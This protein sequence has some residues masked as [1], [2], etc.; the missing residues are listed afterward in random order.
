M[1][2]LEEKW[3]SKT[4]LSQLNSAQTLLYEWV[5]LALTEKWHAVSS[6]SQY[7]QNTYKFIERHFS[8]ISLLD[9]DDEFLVDD[10]YPFVLKDME[11]YYQQKD[12]E[13]PTAVLSSFHR[14]LETLHDI[15]SVKFIGGS[16]I[17]LAT[18]QNQLL[19]EDEYQQ[20]L[21]IV[22]KS[23]LDEASKKH[24]SLSII[25][26]RRL[27]LRKS[28]IFKLKIKD[29][30]LQSKNLHIHGI[31]YDRQKTIRGNRLLPYSALLTIDEMKQFEKYI[32]NQSLEKNSE[33]NLLLF[34]D[35]VKI[36]S[37]TV[38]IQKVTAYIQALLH[39]V[40]G[41][42]KVTIKSFRKTFASEVFLNLTMKD[43]LEDILKILHL[44]R[45]DLNKEIHR[46]FN[47]SVVVK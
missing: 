19:T 44:K 23:K 35:K 17:N 29:I 39:S 5:K 11:N 46:T 14:S 37:K 28:E 24:I 36:Y 30:C 15:D 47:R 32:N 8:Q 10:L 40:T 1:D 31:K 13:V 42:H 21:S 20:C 4:T 43:G 25:L 26:Y 45:L 34:H 9:L 22:Q 16:K 27:G 18:L 2:E 12:S 6:I 41:N 38:V 33:Q 7:F 3:P